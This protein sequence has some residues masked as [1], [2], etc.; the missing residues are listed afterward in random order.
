[1]E[2]K[3]EGQGQQNSESLHFWVRGPSCGLPVPLVFTLLF[4]LSPPKLTE[5]GRGGEGVSVG[6]LLSAPPP[7]GVQHRLSGL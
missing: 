6:I 7:P 5:Q 2:G 4:S 1:M 3:A